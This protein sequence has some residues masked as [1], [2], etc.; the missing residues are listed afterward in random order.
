V[1]ARWSD[2][3]SLVTFGGLISLHAHCFVPEMAGVATAVTFPG[4]EI[5]SLYQWSCGTR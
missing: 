1:A 5:R 4:F 2:S 3:A